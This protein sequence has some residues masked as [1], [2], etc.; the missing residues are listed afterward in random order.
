MPEIISLKDLMGLYRKADEMRK[1]YEEE[2]L[3]AKGE[4]DNRRALYCAMQASH[5]RMVRDQLTDA[6]GDQV[7]FNIEKRSN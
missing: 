7:V 4:N 1:R 2:E 5:W 6:A 3:I